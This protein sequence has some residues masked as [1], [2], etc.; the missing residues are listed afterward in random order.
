MDEKTEAQELT[1]GCDHT[2]STFFTWL[3]EHQAFLIFLISLATPLSLFWASLFPGCWRPQAI[4]HDALFCLHRRECDLY[5]V[6]PVCWWLQNFPSPSPDQPTHI[7]LPLTGISNSAPTPYT[8][9][10]FLLTSENGTV[11]HP[12][13]PSPEPKRC[14]QCAFLILKCHFQS[15]SKS[16]QCYL[17]IIRISHLLTLL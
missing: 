6:I 11:V 15:V 4:V 8:P 17:Q 9:L 10:P 1:C 12:F 16:C 13:P 14:P 7:P 3:P 5:S 2:E